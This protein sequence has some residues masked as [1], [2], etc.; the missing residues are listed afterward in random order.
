LDIETGHFIRIQIPAR[1]RGLWLSPA[2]AVLCGVVASGAFVWTGRDVLIAA[3]A[4]L[5][6]DGAWA[7]AWWGLVETDWPQLIGRWPLVAPDP[8]EPRTRPSFGGMEQSPSFGGMEQSPSFGGIRQPWP[9][10][11]PGSP[12][13]RAQQWAARGRMW[14]H[15]ILWP[16]AG[17]PVLSALVSSGLAVVLSAVIGWPALTLS[18][19]AL[20]L[21]QIGVLL[22]HRHGRASHVAR[23]ALDVGLAWALGHAA[24]GALTPVSIGLAALFAIVYGSSIDLAHGGQ[25]RR[26]W[27]LP[28]AI[29]VL[30]LVVIQQPLAAFAATS[31]LITQALLATVLRG[32]SFAQAAQGWLLLAM[33]A[34]ALAIR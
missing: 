29:V 10:A 1:S 25:Q 31:L 19:G 22:E 14:W 16:E 23:G 11:R 9:L 24:F 27:L 2:W 18:L 21:I 7:T 20:A 15:V 26:G 13:D 28:Q 4:V 33:L 12:A 30:I 3:L 17:T 8:M 32:L 6:A 34:A 5:L